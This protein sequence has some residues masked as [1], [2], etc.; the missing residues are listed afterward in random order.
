MSITITKITPPEQGRVISTHCPICRRTEFMLNPWAKKPE[1]GDYFRF[2]KTC[3]DDKL[4]NVHGIMIWEEEEFDRICGE[5]T[6]S[7]LS[8]L[9]G[10][11]RG[12]V[13]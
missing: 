7:R 3:A 6:A 9:P 1:D 10:S 8:Y 11:N 13:Q 4:S 12:Q 2:N 5:G